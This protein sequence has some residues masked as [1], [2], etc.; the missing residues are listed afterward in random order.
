M[1]YYRYI[2]P[3]ITS[4]L[5]LSLVGT[6]GI[7]GV[8]Y[9]Y[10]RIDT[11]TRDTLPGLSHLALSN[12]YRGQ[13]FV[14]LVRSLSSADPAEMKKHEEAIRSISGI[15]SGHLKEY[16]KTIHTEENRRLFDTMMADREAYVESRDRI[17]AAKHVGN[18]AAALELLDRELMPMYVKYIENSQKLVAYATRN[19]EKQLVEIR[20]FLL[21]SIGFALVSSLLIFIGGFFMGYTR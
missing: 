13:A 16:S 3:I 15:G 7:L 2:R 18:Q 12:Q 17:L 11:I 8:S 20:A 10:S 5:L 21:G 6:A 14:H 4:L 1:N 9:S 19:G